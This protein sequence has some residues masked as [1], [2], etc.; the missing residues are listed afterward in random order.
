MAV[1]NLTLVQGRGV[2]GWV[3]M[4]GNEPHPECTENAKLV[5]HLRDVEQIERV[6]ICTDC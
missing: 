4:Y 2:G 1:L 6:G 5:S 3:S